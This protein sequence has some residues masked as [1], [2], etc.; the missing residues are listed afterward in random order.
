MTAG[1]LSLGTAVN[2]WDDE[3]TGFAYQGHKAVM[4]LLGTGISSTGNS[5]LQEGAKGYREAALSFTAQDSTQ[6][7]LVRGW[8]ETSETVTFTDYDGSTRDVR[9]LS[10][11]AS[12]LIADLWKVTV[13]LQELTEPV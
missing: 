4:P 6:K 1:F 12:L 8:E 11:D 10:F 13:R 7:D 5:T 9:L 3:F 2:L